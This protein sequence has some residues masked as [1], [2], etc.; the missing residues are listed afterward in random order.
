M[1]ERIP[2]PFKSRMLD[3]EEDADLGFVEVEDAKK[4]LEI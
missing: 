2:N 1:S 4:R 3:I